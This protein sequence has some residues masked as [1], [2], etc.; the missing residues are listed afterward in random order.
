MPKNSISFKEAKKR[1]KKLRDLIEK[2]RY[3]YHVLDKPIME[4][5]V[6]D[7]LKHELYALEQQYPQLI[8]PDSPTQRV[9]GEP[10][11]EF[12]K[13]AHST[14]MLS[15][16]DCFSFEELKEWD[17]KNKR[18]LKKNFYTT[19]FAELKIDGLAVSLVY[20]NGVFVQGATRGDGKTGEDITLNLK[21]IEA[22]PLKLRKEGFENV[23]ETRFEVR[24]EV[25]MPTKSFELLNREQKKKGLPTFANPRNA[26]A[27]SVR[28]LDPKI[29]ASRDLDFVAY[30]IVTDIGQKTHEEEHLILEK[31]G[32]K[33]LPQNKLC[34]SLEEVEKFKKYWEKKR[35]SLR[36]WIDGIVVLIND[37]KIYEKLGTVGKAPRGAIAY[38]FSP[39]EATTVIEK[40]IL[41]I[42]RTGIV[43]PV[44]VLKPVQ[45]GGTIVSRAT[46]H[47]EDQIKK[48]DI[49]I[50]DTVV[51]YKAGDII[52]EVLRS[53]KELRPQNTKKFVMPKR[54]PY[55]KS[56]LVKKGAYWFCPK[57]DCFAIKQ[58][59]LQHFVSKNAF[60]IEGLGPKIINQLLQ[61]GLIKNPADLFD[62][63]VDDLKPLERFAE[64]SAENL[65][66]SI[67]QRKEI[68]LGRFIYSLGIRHVGEQT[69]YDLASHFKAIENLKNATLEEIQKVPNVGDVVAKSIYNFFND[70]DNIKLVSDL[71]KKVKVIEYSQSKGKLDGTTF[72]F[73]GELDSMTREEAKEKLRKL[74]AVP[75]SDVFR[76]LD[77][78]VVGKGPGS[79]LTR[80]KKLGVKIINEEEFLKMIK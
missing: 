68:D 34:K 62:L 29:T 14:P 61:N 31:L 71:Q 36:F 74:G 65:V 6:L 3:A 76:G 80:A 56:K 69:A 53:V 60:D 67:Q 40:I 48:K 49:R 72:C 63:K 43:N 17:E 44:A 35:E 7:S 30:D 39:K 38:K 55:C 9:G 59:A 73:T 4:D 24:G 54:C 1:V 45:I 27:G 58:R 26:A 50:G 11:D 46:L 21:T 41:G 18:F 12:K 19:Y 33:I 8:T 23:F 13:V 47:N 5:E 78:L 22:I 15:L 28:Q 37:N 57:R 42:G 52:P 32:F 10:L 66:R 64:K 2:A 77:Y 20:E 51:V 25:F 79:K 16:E 70:K 75:H